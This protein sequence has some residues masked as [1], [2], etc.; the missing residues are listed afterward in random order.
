MLGGMGQEILN[1]CGMHSL[2]LE[3]G[4]VREGQNTDLA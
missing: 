1:A 4:L 2:A 3:G